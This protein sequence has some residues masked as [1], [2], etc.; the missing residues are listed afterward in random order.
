MKKLETLKRFRESSVKMRRRVLGDEKQ[1]THRMEVSQGRSACTRIVNSVQNDYERV[2]G[3]EGL[4]VPV[5]SSIAVIPSD[6]TT[7][8]YKSLD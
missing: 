7:Y 1:G 6:L 5:A 2:G 8:E 4:E 3:G